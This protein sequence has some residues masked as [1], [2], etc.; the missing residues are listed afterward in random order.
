MTMLRWAVSLSCFP[1]FFLI[2]ISPFHQPANVQAEPKSKR[3]ALVIGISDYRHLTPLSNPVRDAKDLATLFRKHGISVSEHFDLDH[4]AFEKVLDDFSKKAKSAEEVYV[5]YAGHGMTAVKDRKLTNVLAPTNA[6]ISCQTR[7]TEH[8]ITMQ[9]IV[10]AIEGVPKQVLLF[11]S[12]RNNPIRDCEN[13]A[14]TESLTG[15]LPVRMAT[16]AD[17]VPTPRGTTEK[18]GFKTNDSK[19]RRISSSILVAYSTDLG[20]SASDGDPGKNS[21]FVSVLL[22]E[23]KADP[24]ILIRKILDQTSSRVAQIAGQRPWVVTKGGE[25][26][27]CLS[28]GACET[29]FTLRNDKQIEQSRS[30]A[31]IANKHINRD[32]FS[33]AMLI[34]L[35]VLPDQ[36]PDLSKVPL[37]SRP[38]V[39]EPEVSL[40]EAQSRNRQLY[41]LQ[42]HKGIVGNVAFSPD[43]A[44]AITSSWDRTARLW[45]VRT[46]EHILTL[47]GHAGIVT[48]AAF[49]PDGTRIVTTATK[50]H[51]RLWDT[52]TGN[53]IADLKGTNIDHYKTIFSK[54]GTRLVTVSGFD[55]Y[56]WDTKTGKKISVLNGHT[57]PISFAAFS[58]DSSRIVTSSWDASVRLWNVRTGRKIIDFKGHKDQVNK[59]I[60]NPDETRIATVSLDRTLRLWDVPSGQEIAALKGHRFIPQNVEFSPDSTRLL[61]STGRWGTAILWDVERHEKIAILQRNKEKSRHAIFSPDGKRIVTSSLESTQLWDGKTGRFIAVMAS[62]TNPKSKGH[63]S[64]ICTPVFSRDSTT[65]ATISWHNAHLWNSQT[66]EW[67]TTLKGHANDIDAVA[68][69]PEGDLIITGSKDRTARIWHTKRYL[70]P[71]IVRGHSSAVRDVSLSS[72]GRSLITASHDHTARLWDR[73]SGNV[74]TIL[75]G[76]KGVVSSAVFSPDG[77]RVLTTSFDKSARLWDT[78]T[79]EEIAIFNGHTDKVYSASF[80]PDGAR[81]VTASQDNTARVWDAKTGRQIKVL[82]GHGDN[83]GM[84]LVHSAVFSSDGK[85]IVT[86]GADSTV[87]VWNANSGNEILVIK[88]TQSRIMTSAVFN[89]NNT[90]I[91]TASTDNTARLWDVKTGRE[92]TVFK[93]H[94]NGIASAVFSPDETRIL[95]ASWDKTARVW[96]TET[97][98]EVAI[99]KG[100]KGR[101]WSAE[102]SPDGTKV[103]TAS[104]DKTVRLWPIFSS[105]QSLVNHVKKIVPHCLSHQQLKQ[106]HLPLEPFRWCITGP[107]LEQERKPT[108]WQPKWPYHTKAWRNWLIARDKGENPRLPITNQ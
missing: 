74:I 34:S 106:F 47:D 22:S 79:S 91:L 60:F 32:E 4:S 104:D 73:K 108:K 11:D 3:I 70:G 56:L 82:R 9:Q 45:N 69:N 35:A 81:F 67:I 65:V 25:P 43:G 16:L 48:S 100:H 94:T 8:T 96:D 19:F 13:N 49:S 20:A 53:K 90:R 80:S 95:T 87:R 83:W 99:L 72:D 54:D 107:G 64:E 41:V 51:A 98:R 105:T 88:G 30:L 21:P 37:S 86:T 75:K 84:K 2:I 40:F 23:L 36:T 102:F 77:K 89:R 10:K 61:T 92:I 63:T 42:G 58:A 24:K 78:N 103:I 71:I 38:Y 97:G 52:K 57:K 5:F 50:D 44:L 55:I 29:N 14:L 31:G 15:F 59:V 46:G 18:Q 66:G 33:T 68:F 28:S 26:K 62:P 7:M 39:P 76:H 6:N 85:F 27:M 101:V 1:L 17:M 12:C 93:G